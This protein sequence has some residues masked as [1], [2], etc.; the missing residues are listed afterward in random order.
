MYTPKD[1]RCNVV[2]KPVREPVKLLISEL[3]ECYGE[4]ID[5][6]ERG[7]GVATMCPLMTGERCMIAFDIDTSTTRKRVN[8]LGTVV[9]AKAEGSSQYRAGIEFID[10]DAYSRLLIRDLQVPERT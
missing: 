6:S 8:A 10:M 4:I 2:R 9:Y 5:I 7:A 1:R 3:V